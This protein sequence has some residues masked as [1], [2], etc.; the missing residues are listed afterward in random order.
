MATVGVKGLNSPSS[1][2]RISMQFSWILFTVCNVVQYRSSLLRRVCVLC[3]YR[4][5]YLYNQ[6][7]GN[8]L[9]TFAVLRFSVVFRIIATECKMPRSIWRRNVSRFFVQIFGYFRFICCELYRST[10]SITLN[11]IISWYLV[12]LLYGIFVIWL[13]NCRGNRL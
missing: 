11:K 4:D 6:Y 5:G 9:S 7:T 13:R 1:E 10:T 3:V 2:V 8:R 12:Q